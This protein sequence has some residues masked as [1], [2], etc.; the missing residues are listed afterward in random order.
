MTTI[1]N[2][3][4]ASPCPPHGEAPG[5]PATHVVTW[6]DG[7]SWDQFV[8]NAADGTVAHRW[9]WTHIVPSAYGHHVTPLAAVRQDELVG[10]LP[11][12]LVRSRIFGRCLVSMPYLDTGGVCTAGDVSAQEALVEA[13]LD[14]ATTARAPLELRHLRDRT[15]GLPAAVH[16]VTMTLDLDGGE[17]AVWRRI[18][19]NRRGQVRKA[20]RNGLSTHVCGADGL[21]DFFAVLATNMRDLGSPMHRREFFAGIVEQFADDARIV[22]VRHD[23]RVVGAG[24]ILFHGDRAVLPWSSSLRSALPLGPNQLLYWEAVRQALERDRRVFDFG[25]SSPRSGTF[26][27]KREWGAQP[28]QLHWHRSLG[29]ASA[30]E[31][32]AQRMAWAVRLWRRL[33]VKVATRVGGLVRGGLP[34]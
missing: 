25:R 28:V 33:P 2:V 3:H 19:S 23:T 13:A 12:V 4:P 27:A 32:D 10:V 21:D 34:Q 16:K 14:L 31:D 15:V 26:E 17:E 8:A 9:A 18:K 1:Q 5:A 20:K 30:S 6:N 29:D 22:L 24:L 7:A 11:L